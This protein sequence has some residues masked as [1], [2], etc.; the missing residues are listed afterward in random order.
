MLFTRGLGMHNETGLVICE[1]P[2][3]RIGISSTEPF[4]T[5]QLYAAPSVS[6]GVLLLQGGSK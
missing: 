3:N 4:K 5:S 6:C 2:I 1:F